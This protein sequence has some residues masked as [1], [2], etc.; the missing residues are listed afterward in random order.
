MPRKS[1]G[2]YPPDW[3]EIAQR[4]KNRHGWKCERCGHEHDVKAGYTLT[5]HHLDLDKSNCEEWNLT[6][7][8]QRC[9]LHVQATCR[10][11]QMLLWGDAVSDWFKPHLEGFIE[12][13]RKLAKEAPDAPA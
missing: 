12:H 3:S 8:C 2:E 9:H 5:V 1:R 4:L 13:R 11:E 7:L 6:V 10:M